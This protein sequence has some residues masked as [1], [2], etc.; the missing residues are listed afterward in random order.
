MPGPQV[1]YNGPTCRRL[2][3]ADMKKNNFGKLFKSLQAGSSRRIKNFSEDI[4]DSEIYTDLLAQIAPKDAGVNK[5][6]MKK[7]DLV[8]RAETMLE[9]ADKIDSREFVTAKVS[10]GRILSRDVVMIMDYLV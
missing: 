9:Q 8:E 6:A 1:K 5:F 3:F 2:L 7:D 10:I 4:K